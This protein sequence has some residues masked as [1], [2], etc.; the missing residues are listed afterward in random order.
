MCKIVA[1]DQP[2]IAEWHA[3]WPSEQVY[4]NISVRSLQ[5]LIP[6]EHFMMVM[7]LRRGGEPRSLVFRMKRT[8]RPA[9]QRIWHEAEVR[10]GRGA[11]AAAYPQMPISLRPFEDDPII[12]RDGSSPCTFVEALEHARHLAHFCGCPVIYTYDGSGWGTA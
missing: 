4:S 2:L 11:L 7:T 5:T 8:V 3:H 12:T 6:D 10:G 1:L 9:G